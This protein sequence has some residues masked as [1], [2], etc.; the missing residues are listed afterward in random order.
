MRPKPARAR[1]NPGL[2]CC[3]F[4]VPGLVVDALDDFAETA[5]DTLGYNVTRANM[6]RAAFAVLLN[7]VKNGDS[8]PV[9]DAIC[10]ARRKRGRKARQPLPQ[11]VVQVEEASV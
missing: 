1:G 5:T 7:V 4:R 9:F 6:A 10:A 8:K 3:I 2:E 11:V